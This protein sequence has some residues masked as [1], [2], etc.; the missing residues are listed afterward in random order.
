MSATGTLQA[1]WQRE[2]TIETSAIENVSEVYLMGIECWVQSHRNGGKSFCRQ[3]V[4]GQST[5]VK[6]R[7][8]IRSPDVN[9]EFRSGHPEMAIG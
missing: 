7:L 6:F 2:G 4:T 5:P 3:R 1:P 9:C 8:A